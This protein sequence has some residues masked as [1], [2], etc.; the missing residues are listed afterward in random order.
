[1]S[2]EKTNQ[3]KKEK[4]IEFQMLS[5]QYQKLSEQLQALEQQI[6]ELLKLDAN[7][8]DLAQVKDNTL[9]LVPFGAGILV[10]TLIKTSRLVVNVGSNT[11]VEKNIDESRNLVKKQVTD[12]QKIQEQYQKEL[13]KL[14]VSIQILQ[15]QLTK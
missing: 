9:S 10:P 2:Q 4:Y 7:L 8:E 6:L 12:L 5:T 11:L 3:N 1:M 14:G 13:S 15:G